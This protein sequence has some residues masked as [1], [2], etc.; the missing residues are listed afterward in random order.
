MCLAR[1]LHLRIPV[2]SRGCSLLCSIQGAPLRPGLGPAEAHA[3][4]N[5]AQGVDEYLHRGAAAVYRDQKTVDVR[6]DRSM[7][8]LRPAA[9]LVYRLK[10]GFD[11][12]EIIARKFA[13]MVCRA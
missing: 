13:Q 5:F 9:L 3:K 6:A 8:F 4:D 10:A 1:S 11:I 7:L 2:S 12:V